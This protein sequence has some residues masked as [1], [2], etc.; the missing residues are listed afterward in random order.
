MLFRSQAC[1]LLAPGNERHW[2]HHFAVPPAHV[3]TDGHWVRFARRAGID[4]RSLPHAYLA[5][6]A[7]MPGA[8]PLAPRSQARGIGRPRA[9]D[10]RTH[11]MA[12]LPEGVAEMARPGGRER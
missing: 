12:C 5:M 9:A 3:F 11:G 8:V 6:Q 7:R 10:E 1:P 2:C 4:L